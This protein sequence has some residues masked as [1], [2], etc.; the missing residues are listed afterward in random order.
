MKVNYPPSSALGHFSAPVCFSR[1][2]EGGQKNTQ[3]L[4]ILLPTQRGEDKH[5]DPTFA[6]IAQRSLKELRNNMTAKLISYKEEA[7]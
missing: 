7:I 4:Y 6:Y 5:P 1:E 2:K 3:L